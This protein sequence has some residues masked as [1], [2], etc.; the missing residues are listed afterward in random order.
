MKSWV[1]RSAVFIA[2]VSYCVTFWKAL[3]LLGADFEGVEDIL[4]PIPWAWRDQT[5]SVHGQMV[6]SSFNVVVL[7]VSK[8]IFQIN[9]AGCVVAATYPSITWMGAKQAVR[10]KISSSIE[11]SRTFTMSLDIVCTFSLSVKNTFISTICKFVCSTNN[12]GCR[13]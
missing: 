3:F 13:K 7:F 4:W 10:D 1:K 5:M 9:H 2:I 6:Q 12:R 8:A 11:R